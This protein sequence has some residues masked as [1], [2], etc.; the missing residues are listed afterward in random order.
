MK[1]SQYS[2]KITQICL[3]DTA[4][5]GH[6]DNTKATWDNLAKNG[7][8]VGTNF[9]IGGKLNPHIWKSGDLNQYDGEIL[10][11]FELDEFSWQLGVMLCPQYTGGITLSRMNAASL[12]A[13]NIGIEI[14]N[15]EYAIPKGDH[16]ETYFST[17]QYPCIIPE[18][19][20]IDLGREWR[21]H[22]YWHN[23]TDAQI[24]SL[25][26]LLLALKS[27]FDIDFS[28]FS[29][30]FDDW[31]FSEAGEVNINALNGKAGIWNHTNYRSEKGDL[32]PDK[33]ILEVLNFVKDA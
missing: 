3:H 25:A 8:F 10:Q 1:R 29:Q 7:N 27:K 4:G 13:S 24:D 16:F 12:E 15:Y 19:E 30:G 31:W 20:I 26:N 18:E 32:H 33:R 6:P 17:P 22:R 14:C 23:Y 5:H 2:S 11:A 9:I 21:G 28:I